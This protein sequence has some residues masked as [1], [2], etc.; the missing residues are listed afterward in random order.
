MRPLVGLS[1]PRGNNGVNENNGINES[2]DN[3]EPNDLNGSSDINENNA[4][5]GNNDINE[6]NEIN[7]SSGINDN[8]DTNGINE[9]NEPNEIN[10][11]GELPEIASLTLA[12]TKH[13]LPSLR[14]TRSGTRQSQQLNSSSEINGR[15]GTLEIASLRQ[16]PFNYAQDRQ[17]RLCFTPSQ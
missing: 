11:I 2:N 7:G 17:G 13:P 8:S 5:N 9:S 15:K 1:A 14:V 6:S 16:A 12:M 10:D 4:I 3:S